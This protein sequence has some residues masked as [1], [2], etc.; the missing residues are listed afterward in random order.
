MLY[1]TVMHGSHSK[2]AHARYR[3]RTC[4]L[5]ACEADV[6]GWPVPSHCYSFPLPHDEPT[7]VMWPAAQHIIVCGQRRA[8]ML[9][10]RHASQAHSHRTMSAPT[11]TTVAPSA[12]NVRTWPRVRGAAHGNRVFVWTSLTRCA[13]LRCVRA[14][15]PQQ[16]R[17]RRARIRYRTPT[18]DSQQ[19]VC[20]GVGSVTSASTLNRASEGACMSTAQPG[21]CCHCTPQAAE[22]Q[23]LQQL[24]RQQAQHA[25]HAM[26][27]WDS[28]ASSSGCGVCWLWP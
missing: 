27:R 7:P 6:D 24:L 26:P 28:G 20:R 10:M 12:I 15:V 14:C 22:P 21:S 3:L 19:Q 4:I 11:Q 8:K 2:L 1:S 9:L 13:G 17:S 16:S 5:A 23:T 18:R 25:Q